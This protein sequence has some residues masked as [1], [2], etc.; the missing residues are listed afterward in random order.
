MSYINNNYSDKN[1]FNILKF[2]DLNINK[3]YECILYFLD[4]TNYSSMNL[5]LMNSFDKIFVIEKLNKY[6]RLFSN[7]LVDLKIFDNLIFNN[8]NIDIISKY[9]YK[10]IFNINRIINRKEFNFS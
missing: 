7:N 1:N 9:Y 8:N 3:K 6:F 10:N 4:N 2:T 5:L